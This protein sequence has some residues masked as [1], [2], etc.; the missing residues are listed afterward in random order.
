MIF[1]ITVILLLMNMINGV[2]VSTFSQIREES[3]EKDDDINNNCFICSINRVEFEKRNIPFVKHLS[4]EHNS[5]NYIKFLVN[6]KLSCEKD[7]DSD[8]FYIIKCVKNN[9]VA[10]FPVSKSLSLGVIEGKDEDNNEDESEGT[11]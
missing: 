5:R 11:N 10:C 9:D 6:L 7:L 4:A 3:Q 1:Y 8:Q 2:I